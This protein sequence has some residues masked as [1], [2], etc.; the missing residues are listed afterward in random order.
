MK[1]KVI[2]AID[3]LTVFNGYLS[4]EEY[5]KFLLADPNPQHLLYVQ[6]EDQ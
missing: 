1:H 6:E 4:D 5:K 2:I 3:G